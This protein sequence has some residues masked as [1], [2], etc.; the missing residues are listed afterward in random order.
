M[1]QDY[2]FTA[3]DIYEDL[4]GF[5]VVNNAPVDGWSVAGTAEV[6]EGHCYILRLGGDEGCHYVKIW[7]TIVT[8]SYT[9]FWWAYQ[10]DP[11]NRDL[12]PGPADDEEDANI[13]L[14]SGSG[15]TGGIKKIKGF[16]RGRQ[17]PP[18]NSSGVQGDDRILQRQNTLP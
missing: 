12:M 18:T 6:I 5:D 15:E 16:P 7:V 10:T 14:T 11:D 3:Y 17:V 1:I 9:E 13:M 8:T 4:Y 2:G